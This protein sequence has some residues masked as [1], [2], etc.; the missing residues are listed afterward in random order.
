MHEQPHTATVL[1]FEDGNPVYRATLD[2]QA[3]D[4]SQAGGGE[5]E[6]YLTEPGQ[7]ELYGWHEHAASHEWARLAFDP[8]SLSVE[9]KH[10]PCVEV[11]FMIEAGQSG[12][13]HSQFLR[14][15]GCDGDDGAQSSK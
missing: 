1:L 3:A 7:Y 11:I 14:N 8:E 4:G 10:P 15:V 6:G 2:A 12:G 9:S 5:F 13:A